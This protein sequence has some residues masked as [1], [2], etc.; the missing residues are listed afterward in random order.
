[1]K[2]GPIS[3]DGSG[4]SPTTVFGS[5]AAAGGAILL[6]PTV[7]PQIGTEPHWLIVTAG[8]MAVVGTVLAHGGAA[9]AK[10]VTPAVTTAA[11]V[12]TAPVNKP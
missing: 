8:V 10:D 6:A 12:T 4:F 2:I 1:M 5:I 7:Y 3:I 11:T 9:N